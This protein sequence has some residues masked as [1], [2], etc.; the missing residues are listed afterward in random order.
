MKIS[1]YYGVCLWMSSWLGND[2]VAFSPM[3]KDMTTTI[4]SKSTL[5]A[6]SS[7]SST[8]REVLVQSLLLAGGIPMPAVAASYAQE[9][10]DKEKIVKGLQ[11]L[12]YLLDNWEK[13]T[14]VC[15]R[16]DNPYIGCERTPEKV[17]EVSS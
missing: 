15:N 6:E 16:T 11:R 4:C 9:T 7:S 8:R 1:Y 10:S 12:T 17:M 5:N 13:E 2:V 3:K 14:T